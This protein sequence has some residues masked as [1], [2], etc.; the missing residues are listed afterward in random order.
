M[1][2]PRN[3]TLLQLAALA[4]G[5]LGA[6]V[7]FVA[8]RE[9]PDRARYERIRDGMTQEEVIA[10]MGR[11]P[12]VTIDI[13]SRGIGPRETRHFIWRTAGGNEAWVVDEGRGV[14]LKGWNKPSQ[15]PFWQRLRRWLRL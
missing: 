10:V 14:G 7:A 1:T 9:D 2:R 4:L 11:T 5:L 15:E 12:D 6:C 3:R 8:T 13:G